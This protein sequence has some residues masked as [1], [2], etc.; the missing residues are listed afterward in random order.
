ME[1]DWYDLVRGILS[2]ER[3]GQRCQ[4]WGQGAWTIRASALAKIANNREEGDEQVGTQILPGAANHEG[5]LSAWNLG[6]TD[7]NQLLMDMSEESTRLSQG[8]TREEETTSESSLDI[9]VQGDTDESSGNE[10]DYSVEVERVP[11]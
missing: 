7:R 5:Q 6:A 4:P 9:V 2:H 3:C 1:S 10:A 8:L 11:V